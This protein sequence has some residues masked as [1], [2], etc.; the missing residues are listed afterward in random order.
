MA[1]IRT[2]AYLVS[3][4]YTDSIVD[5]MCQTQKYDFIVCYEVTFICALY[6]PVCVRARNSARARK[7]CMYAYTCSVNVCE[8]VECERIFA[9]NTRVCGACT[10]VYR[11][12]FTRVCTLN[13]CVLIRRCR[14]LHVLRAHNYR[15]ACVCACVWIHV[16]NMFVEKDHGP[17]ASDL[18]WFGLYKTIIIL[19]SSSFF[20]LINASKSCVINAFLLHLAERKSRYRFS[21]VKRKVSKT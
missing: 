16:S 17:R 5:E 20:P 12:G 15:Y 19:L 7:N 11:A 3:Y 2:W 10:F 4:N 8:D 6:M 13:V 1:N 21:S 18:V 9:V 14:N